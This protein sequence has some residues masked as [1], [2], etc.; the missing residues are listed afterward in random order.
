LIVASEEENNLLTGSDPN[1][2]LTLCGLNVTLWTESGEIALVKTPFPSL[3]NL[4]CQL[5]VFFV[6]EIPDLPRFDDK[7]AIRRVAVQARPLFSSEIRDCQRSEQ[8]TQW[9]EKVMRFHSL[10]SGLTSSITDG[11]PWRDSRPN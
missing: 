3:Y 7:D 2:M 1:S 10:S 6:R 9:N 5:A 8:Q 4:K 11:C